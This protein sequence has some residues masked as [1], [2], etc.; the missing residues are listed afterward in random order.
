MQISKEKIV[1]GI[2][3]HLWEVVAY[4]KWLHVESQLYYVIS[5]Q[6]IEQLEALFGSVF[7]LFLVK[8]A[9]GGE[10]WGGEFPAFGRS[11]SPSSNCYFKLFL[12]LKLKSWC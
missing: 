5:G 10:G 3:S 2:G 12:G 7:P 9:G 1:S 8:L 6:G 11:D 4:E